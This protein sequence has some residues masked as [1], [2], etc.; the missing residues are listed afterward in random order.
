MNL[1]DQH[2]IWPASN[3]DLAKLVQ[4]RRHIMGLTQDQA[5]KR[6]GVSTYSWVR[7]E[8][9]QR[10]GNANESTVLKVLRSLGIRPIPA[11]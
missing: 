3:R 1:N 10:T 2:I 4:S 7:I 6:A 8:R 11:N 5:A 9:S